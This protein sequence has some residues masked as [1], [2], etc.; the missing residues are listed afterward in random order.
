MLTPAEQI[1]AK[2]ATLVDERALWRWMDVD[3]DGQVLF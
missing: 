1:A 2:S 3:Q